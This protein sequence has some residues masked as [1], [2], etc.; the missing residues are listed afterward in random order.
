LQALVRTVEDGDLPKLPEPDSRGTYAALPSARASLTR[1]IIRQRESAD[2]TQTDLARHAG[3]RPK[4]LSRLEKGKSS[5]DVDM[6]DKVI[7]VLERVG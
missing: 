1:R 2:L 5:P 6:V 7:R 3:L 4:T